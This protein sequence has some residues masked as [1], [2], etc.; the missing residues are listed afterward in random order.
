MPKNDCSQD[1]QKMSELSSPPF[2]LAVLALA[3]VHER[4]G[5]G[6]EKWFGG[7]K[8]GLPKLNIPNMSNGRE[9]FF[10]QLG[11]S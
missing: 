3:Y 2:T 6:L 11:F 4:G 1:L 5:R 10:E 9:Y 8:D 7:R